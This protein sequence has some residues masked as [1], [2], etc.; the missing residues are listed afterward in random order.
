MKIRTDF[1]TNSSSSSFILKK[2]KGIRTVDDA[3]N[4]MI[5]IYREWIDA[6]NEL[7]LVSYNLGL[8][9]V[10][11]KGELDGETYGKFIWSSDPRNLAM[12]F[13][14]KHI[15]E[16]VK[17]TYGI[18]LE[19]DIPDVELSW[20]Q[21]T[22]YKQ[23]ES[24]WVARYG[25][26]DK[27]QALFSIRDLSSPLDYLPLE[28]GICSL[29]ESGESLEK[30]EASNLLGWYAPC[31]FVGRDKYCETAQDVYNM[32]DT[33]AFEGK[34]IGDLLDKQDELCNSCHCNDNSLG[35][36][37]PQMCAAIR[38]KVE[39][40]GVKKPTLV[41]ELLGK[42]CIHSVSGYLPDYVV[43][44]LREIANF[45]NTHMG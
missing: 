7:L 39:E 11:S 18:N 17:S 34:K 20:M 15:V 4:L 36:S 13:Q 41:A 26:K 27:Y 14:R 33:S 9:Y 43:D 8:E 29:N 35:K 24:Y 42:I 25:H 38:R 32:L 22:S 5:K 10:V 31:I 2:V 28:S 19:E 37:K 30:I 1:I 40:L 21:F 3:F 45:S 6:K 44:R 12:P 23:Y 16:L